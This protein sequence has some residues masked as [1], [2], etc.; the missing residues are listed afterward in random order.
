MSLGRS[1]R[2]EVHHTVPKKI[3]TQRTNI[4]PII[5]H[6]YQ[7]QSEVGALNRVSKLGFAKLAGMIC[8]LLACCT[9]PVVGQ[10]V[11]ALDRLLQQGIASHENNRL[12]EAQRHFSECL[13]GARRI[14]HPWYESL[15]LVWLGECAF[16]KQGYAQLLN[17]SLKAKRIVDQRMRADTVKHYFVILQNAGVASSYL[18][19]IVA[20]RSYYRAAFEFHKANFPTDEEMLA[21]AYFNL[22]AAYYKTFALDSAIIWMDSTLQIAK[23]AA[24]SDLRASTLLNKGVIDM[25]LYDYDKAIQNLQ[26]A[27]ALTNDENEKTLT[28]CHLADCHT[29]LKQLD[30]ALKH[31]NEASELVARGESLDRQYHY[32]VE[33]RK[34]QVFYKSDR[35]AFVRTLDN[36]YKSIPRD[37]DN[38]VGDY[39]KTLNWRVQA[40]LD[41]GEY[42]KAEATCREALRTHSDRQFPEVTIRTYQLLADALS[43][44]GCYKEALLSL[45]TAL[46][47]ITPG[48]TSLRIQDNPAA[49]QF[50]NMEFGVAILNAKMKVWMDMY[51]AQANTKALYQAL[52]VYRTADTLLYDRRRFLH[53]DQSRGVL[54]ATAQPLHQQAVALLF[55]LYETEG[56]DHWIAAAFRCMERSR[57]LLVSENLARHHAGTSIPDSIVRQERLLQQTSYRLQQLISQSEQQGAPPTQRRQW[58][59]QRYTTEQDWGALLDFIEVHYPAYFKTK[60]SLPFANPSDVQQRLLGRREVMLSFSEQDSV[61]YCVGIS[62]HNLFF[63]RL[64]M[65]EPLHR[66]IPALREALMTRSP[67]YY[68]SA[69]RLYAALL[70]PMAPEWKGKDLVLLPDGWL[71]YVP[72]GALPTR[73]AGARYAQ[74]QDFLVTQTSL[75]WLYAVHGALMPRMER[76]RTDYSWAV[77]APFSQDSLNLGTLSLPALPGSRQEGR[78]VEARLGRYPGVLRLGPD[79]QLREL[80]QIAPYT[81]VMHLI[82]HTFINSR[83]PNLSTLYFA[84]GPDSS[85]VSLTIYD[86]ISRQWPFDL[87]VLSACE[88]N[89]GPL[90]GNEGVAGIAR[91]FAM[92]GCHNLVATL[93]V[94]NDDSTIALM[95]AYYAELAKGCGKAHALQRAQ[96]MYVEHDDHLLTLHPYYWAGFIHIGDDS[97]LDLPTSP[98]RWMVGS[99]LL[100]VTGGLGWRYGVQK[101]GQR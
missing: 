90:Q 33:L 55:T 40:Q 7:Y 26:Q 8:L 54:S 57:T 25:S 66:A 63:K 10:S 48:F 78:Q 23:S 3:N 97:P 61:V 6:H 60:Y 47:S 96:Q 32:M 80:E 88:S 30:K 65:D 99:L 1:A 74:D 11:A 24:L 28:H 36:L 15:A 62:K 73:A 44:Q 69:H 53:S 9:A 50:T 16:S 22:S 101:S 75:R 20:Q 85:R 86:I 2:K 77:F 27:L 68:A 89:D 18:G 21:N 83:D 43:K 95:D 64:V 4:I 59:Q 17:Y 91:G 41:A 34:C 87:T 98:I 46:V 51:R 19:D 31:L 58:E 49:V 70:A 84:P 12:K 5:A 67:A 81:Q 29:E 52:N 13:D 79:A 45:Q 42:A 56:H 39:K 35:E 94:V 93:W 71:W 37:D 100:L 72:F 14:D 76:T 92:A 38:V 82:S